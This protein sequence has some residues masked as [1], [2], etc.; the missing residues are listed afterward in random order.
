MA[1]DVDCIRWIWVVNNPQNALGFFIGLGLFGFWFLLGEF[2][3]F[4]GWI[5][6]VIRLILGWTAIQFPSR[7]IFSSECQA[8]EDAIIRKSG[9]NPVQ[10]GMGWGNH[11][12]VS[13]RYKRGR[14]NQMTFDSG[15][16]NL[17]KTESDISPIHS[18]KSSEKQ[19]DLLPRNKVI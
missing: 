8:G 2:P 11:P 14:R 16:Q 1:F 17:Y 6:W 7:P 4:V 5:S 18:S 15:L 10:V 19:N 12:K 13:P 3:V 9:F